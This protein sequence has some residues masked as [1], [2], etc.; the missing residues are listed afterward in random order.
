MSLTLWFSLVMVCILGAI[1]PGPSLAVVLR[2]SIYSTKHG[3]VVAFAHGIGVGLYALLSVLG[4]SGLVI[5]SPMLYQALV[6]GGALYL[7]YMG[8]KALISKGS[9]F[10]LI[11]GNPKVQV[12]F[13]QAAQ[14]GFAI[15]FLNPKL[16]VFFVALF[17]Q[18]ID[19]NSRSFVYGGIMVVTVLAIDIIWYCIV[20]GLVHQTRER[21]ALAEKSVLID[22][23]AGVAFIGL[24]I[25]AVTL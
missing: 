13:R 14:D 17:S 21:F 1:S 7:L 5:G 9:P 24:S 10:Q 20:A 8:V 2:H 18:F 25:R 11:Q 6:Y 23:I 22:R 12:S 4:L 16:L 19:A 3:I 15:A